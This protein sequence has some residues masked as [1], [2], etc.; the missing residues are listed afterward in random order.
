MSI[1]SC[2]STGTPLPSDVN[3]ATPLQALPDELPEIWPLYAEL[4][5]PPELLVPASPD[6]AT[7]LI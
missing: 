6:E 1:Y 5:L 7:E 2:F 4:S 3:L